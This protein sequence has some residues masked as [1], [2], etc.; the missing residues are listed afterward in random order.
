[1]RA[2]SCRTQ[3]PP[4]GTVPRAKAMAVFIMVLLLA[5]A[6][7]IPAGTTVPAPSS[8]RYQLLPDSHLIDDCPPCG[9]PTVLEP[10]R[11]TFDLRLV[12][13]NPLFSRYALENIAF[14]AGSIAG[15]TYKVVGT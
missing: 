11:G 1:M 10:L 6:G 7:D 12:E 2:A 9:R 3:R 5:S 15:R 14:T 13:G 4:G 8:W